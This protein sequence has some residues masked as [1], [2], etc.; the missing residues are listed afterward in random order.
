MIKDIGYKIL[1]ISLT[2]II[3]IM[4]I[5]YSPRAYSPDVSVVL[6]TQTNTVTV[7]ATTTPTD[8][9]G[10]GTGSLT[11]PANTVVAGRQWLLKI[12]GIYSTPTLSIGNLLVEVKLGSVTLASATANSLAATATNLAYDAELI[13]TCRSNG[14]SGTVMTT[15]NLEYDAAASNV[16]QLSLA[17]NSAT[18]T[19]TINFT[20][21]NAFQAIAT[22]SN[23]TAGNSVSSLNCSLE[24][25]N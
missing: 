7:A 11:I 9:L 13:F 5:A 23:N 22:W 18:G 25:L 4:V 15:G 8:L 6:F 20:N 10:T 17:F 24:Q 3:I 16:A 19:S 21:S 14:A 1:S 2:L 12:H